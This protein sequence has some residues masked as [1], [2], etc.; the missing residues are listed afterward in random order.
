MQASTD[1]QALWL[2]S[3]GGS[4]LTSAVTRTWTL[5]LP[6][7]KYVALRSYVLYNPFGDRMIDVAHESIGPAFAMWL[8]QHVCSDLLPQKPLVGVILARQA[9]LRAPRLPLSKRET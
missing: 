3:T 5:R 2:V 4:A 7:S 6:F 9:V 8:G 1:W